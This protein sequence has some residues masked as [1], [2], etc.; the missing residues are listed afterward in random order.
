MHR[1]NGS[2]CLPVN[3]WF[4]INYKRCP[5]NKCGYGNDE[6]LVETCSGRKDEDKSELPDLRKC[7]IACKPGC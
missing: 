4:P 5:E 2:S 7:E 1:L 3:I 6:I